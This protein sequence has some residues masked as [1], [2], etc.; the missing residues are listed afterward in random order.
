MSKTISHD[1]TY[2]ALL[3]EILDSGERH[4]DRTGV[5]TLSVFGRQI[6]FDLRQGF[7]LLTTKKMSIMNI[8]NELKWFL[9]GSTDVKA[10]QAMGTRIWDEWAT[11]EQCA[12]FGRVPGDLGPVYGAL[13]RRYPVGVSADDLEHIMKGRS[14]EEA[15]TSVDQ[16][17]ELIKDMIQSP[18]SRRLIVTGWHPYYA[19]RVTLP[20]CHTLW[21][22]KVHEKTQEASLH[23]Y[24]R[25]IDTFLGLPYNIASYAMLLHLLCCIT[26]Y[27]PRDLIISFG[28]VHVYLNH[29][30]QARLQLSREPYQ[31]PQFIVNFEPGSSIF[32]GKW[33]PALINYQCHPAI[34]AEVAI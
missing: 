17:S 12:K 14:A 19:K 32:E 15:R 7:P 8:A 27:A 11:A 6:R 18:N 34:R 10:L 1:L 5:G 33:N 9:S 22:V 13:W 25:S 28:D 23:L 4:E 3:Q 30:E 16:I 2:L 21:Q 26:G 31:S 20:P 24:A 29:L